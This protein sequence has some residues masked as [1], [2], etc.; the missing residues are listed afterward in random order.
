[1]T[2]EEILAMEA[3]RELDKLIAERVMGWYDFWEASGYLMGYPPAEQAMGIEAERHP[4]PFY[5]EQDYQ[6]VIDEMWVKGHR[7][8]MIAEG[9]QGWV[10]ASFGSQGWSVRPVATTGLQEAIALATCKAALLA[11]TPP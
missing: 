11:L 9:S 10:T 7:F 4:V 6:L 1:M 5:S 2:R 8:S 3:G